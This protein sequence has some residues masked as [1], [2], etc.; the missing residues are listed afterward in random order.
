MLTCLFARRLTLLTDVLFGMCDQLTVVRPV[1]SFLL[2][3]QKVT[4]T[5]KEKRKGKQCNHAGETS[6]HR[7]FLVLLPNALLNHAQSIMHLHH[8]CWQCM[9]A[10]RI[11]VHVHKLWHASYA[12]TAMGSWCMCNNLWHISEACPKGWPRL[13]LKDGKS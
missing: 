6:R 12:L 2:Q 9:T 1:T 7:H 13:N 8:L 5:G 10:K 4:Q 3:N 11:V